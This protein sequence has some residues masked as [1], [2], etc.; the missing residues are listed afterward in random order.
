MLENGTEAWGRFVVTPIPIIMKITFF[1]LNNPDQVING[2][3][4]NV[5]EI[6]PYVYR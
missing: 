3:K 1:K 4:P 5:S 6:G 2:A